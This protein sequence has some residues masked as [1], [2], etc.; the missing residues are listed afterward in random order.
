MESHSL[1]LFEAKLSPKTL[2]CFGN[3]EAG[4]FFDN[5]VF[6]SKVPNETGGFIYSMKNTETWKTIVVYIRG[7]RQGW[8]PPIPTWAPGKWEIPKK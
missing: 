7:V 3:R 5:G 8:G 4:P 6:L 2:P 1:N